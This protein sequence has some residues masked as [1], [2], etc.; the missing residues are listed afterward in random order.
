MSPNTQPRQPSGTPVGGQFVGKASPESGI[1]LETLEGATLDGGVGRLASEDTGRGAP[2]RLTNFQ[3]TTK[4][5]PI[6]PNEGTMAYI[7]DRQALLQNPEGA[8]SQ[9]LL[10]VK[11]VV[12]QHG[13]SVEHELLQWYVD[14]APSGD[15]LTLIGLRRALGPRPRRANLLTVVG[16]LVDLGL[17]TQEPGGLR[18]TELGRSTLADIGNAVGNF[19]TVLV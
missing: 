5:H 16:D 13:E 4:R 9:V 1:E 12:D 8:P 19:E 18:L 3:W 7:H 14:V 15:N 6:T 2:V 11:Q 17:L 10:L